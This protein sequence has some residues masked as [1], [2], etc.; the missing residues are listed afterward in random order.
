MSNRIA[1]VN[2]LLKREISAVVEKSFEFPD[3]LVTVHDVDTSADLKSARVFVGVLGAERPGPS[4]VDRLNAKAGFIQNAV[5]K[6]VVLRYTPQLDFR[7]DESIER[8][9]RVLNILDE[10]D[11]PEDPPESSSNASPDFPDSPDDEEGR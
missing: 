6:R 4:V 3:Q 11:V 7:L 1:R 5:V 9:V 2:E 8:G 10:L